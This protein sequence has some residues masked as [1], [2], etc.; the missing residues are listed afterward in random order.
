MAAEGAALAGAFAGEVAQRWRAPDLLERLSRLPALLDAPGAQLL[1]A[2]RNRNIRLELPVN[3]RNVAMMVKAFG[4][5]SW[6]RDWRDARRG[7]KARRTYEAAVHLER[8]G[9]GTPAPI[10]YLERWEGSRL[11]E[12]YYLA[13]FQDGAQ[14]MRDALLQLYDDRPPQAARF[15]GLLECV[16]TGMRGMHEAGFLHNDFGA[17]NVL[18]RS[19]GAERWRDFRVVDLNRGR[20][21]GVLGLRQRAFDLSRLELPS[22]LVQ[23]FAEMYWGGIP[24]RGLLGWNRFFRWRYS[25]KVRL[26]RWRSALR[27]QRRDPS[28]RDYPEARDIWIWDTPTAQPISALLRRDRARFYPRSRGRRMVLDTLRATPAVW[29]AYRELRTQAYARPVEMKGRI[30]VALEPTPATLEQ[31]LALLA[32]LGPVP[33]LVRFYHHDAPEQLRFRIELV[34][35]LRRAGH[36]VGIALVQDRRALL[37]PGSWSAFGSA[38]LEGVAELVESVE[39]GHAVNRVK[40]GVWGFEEL[41]AL[42]APLGEWRAR[43]PGL[44]FTG[45]AAIDFEF[46][47]VFPA[48]RE[49]PADV[50][51]AA[52]SHHL[53]VD[54]R[55]APENPQSGFGPLEKFALGQAVA[56]A[57]GVDRFVVSEVNWPLR[58]TGAH[59]PIHAPYFPPWREAHDTGVTEQEYGAYLLR[60]LCLALCSGMVERV[61]WW[62]LAA[63]GYGLVDDAEPAALRVRPAYRMLQRFLEVVGDATYL[64]AQM[65]PRRGERH[66]AYRFDFRRPDG[67]RVAFAYAHGP[68]QPMPEGR[69]EDASGKPV[70]PAWLD[71]QPHYLRGARA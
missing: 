29:R 48:L 40:W 24:P 8:H 39:V 61:Y 65:P 20:I 44:R 68:A 59:A 13:E 10:G 31:E 56:R 64:A 49:W 57:A 32:G 6:L 66:G 50:P 34:R 67:E 43:H 18:L 42:Y 9:A 26:R 27:G 25:H 62:R 4:R 53:Y 47:A 35:A 37:H 45:P 52:L 51:L 71:G 15:V 21:R 38:V 17:Q 28:E 46:P 2:G 19:D 63:H 1:A 54:R 60:Y 30:G 14:T 3:G 11:R 55:G 22:D 33:A 41:R 70:A 36:D 12:S 23:I 5:Q 58:G 7:S 69:A 16:A